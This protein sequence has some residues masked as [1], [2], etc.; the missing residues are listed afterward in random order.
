LRRFLKKK[1]KRREAK[2]K[3]IVIEQL[4][5]YQMIAIINI[6]EEFIDTDGRSKL[7]FSLLE[8]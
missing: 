4:F 3:E 6:T 7:D 1:S 5:D 2:N 8:W